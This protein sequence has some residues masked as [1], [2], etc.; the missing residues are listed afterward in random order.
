MPLITTKINSNYDES[1]MIL[2]YPMVLVDGGVIVKQIKNLPQQMIDDSTIIGHAQQE[3][4]IDEEVEKPKNTQ[5]RKN[6]SDRVTKTNT[7]TNM[8]T[9]STPL[10]DGSI[11]PCQPVFEENEMYTQR[12]ELQIEQ[13]RNQSQRP[14]KTSPAKN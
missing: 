14:M 5:R 3:E 9:L 6:S 1:L 8:A 4:M 2:N 11:E 13:I 7:T 10:D 12:L